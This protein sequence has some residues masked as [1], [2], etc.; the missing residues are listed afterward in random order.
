M[1]TSQRKLS[2]IIATL[3]V[4]ATTSKNT[5]KTSY[6]SV[7]S[8]QANG[9]PRRLM[10]YSKSGIK[11]LKAMKPGVPQALIGHFGTEAQDGTIQSRGVFFPIGESTP[12][13][14]AT[15]EEASA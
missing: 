8:T 13:E 6:V 3:T 12:R 11:A 10:T 5:N 2:R 14:V 9:K 4:K 15:S 1:P 7:M